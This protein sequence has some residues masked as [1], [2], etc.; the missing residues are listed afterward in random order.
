MRGSRASWLR[1]MIRSSSSGSRTS[2]MPVQSATTTRSISLAGIDR[3]KLPPLKPS[4]DV[5]SDL[6]PEVASEMGLPPGVKVVMGS[7]DHQ[8]ACIGSGAVRDFEGHVYIG[9]SSWV[10]CIVPFKKTD[11][12]HSIA[13][14][15]PPAK[16]PERRRKD[17]AG[18][19][20]DFL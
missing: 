9:T 12:L 5:L 15:Q 19:C 7:P 4:T 20:L 14:F 3:E 8:C 10:Q 6:L 13:S 2:G 11:V 18:G 17:I 1:P 16:V